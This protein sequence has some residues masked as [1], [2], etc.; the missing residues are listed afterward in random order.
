MLIEIE[1]EEMNMVFYATGTYYEI[2]FVQNR[3]RIWMSS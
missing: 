3:L 2:K 1:I